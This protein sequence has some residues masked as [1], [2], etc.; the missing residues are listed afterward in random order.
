MNCRKNRTIF[1]IFLIFTIIKTP[2]LSFAANSVPSP[3]LSASDSVVR[4]VSEYKREY[5]TG[6]GFVISSDGGRVLIA[7]NYHVVEDNPISIAVYVDE[8]DTIT[9]HIICFSKQQ[10]LCIL[11]LDHFIKLQPIPLEK[12]NVSRGQEIYAIG[13]PASA[14]YLSD[15]FAQKSEEATITN[16]IISAIRELSIQNYG[17]PVSILQIN[18]D[19]NSGNS[20]GP[21]LNKTGNVVGINTYGVNDA[22]GINGAVNVSEL[23]NL[24]KD[25]NL[26]IHY[27]KN[28]GLSKAFIWLSLG[29][30]AVVLIIGVVL[31]LKKKEWIGKKKSKGLSLSAFLAQYPNGMMVRN[32]ISLLLPVAFQIQDYHNNGSLHLQVNPD[33]ILF[34][35][36]KAMLVTPSGSIQGRYSNGF[37]APEVF[38]GVPVNTSADVYSFASVLYYAITGIVP[39]N[40]NTRADNTL[41]FPINLFDETIKEILQTAMSLNPEERFSSMKDL[42][43]T[44]QPYSKENN[45]AQMIEKRKISSK[46]LF[47]TNK[48]NTIGIILG[49]ILG[50]FAIIYGITFGIAS[51]KASK[52]D[53]STAQ[54]FL[55]I[56]AVT[57]IH[58]S[59][60]EGYI[61]AGAA[62]EERHF[63]EAADKYLEL[64][65]YKDSK[66][67]YYESLTDYVMQLTNQNEYATAKSVCDQLD[68]EE[69]TN[70]RLLQLDV[71]FREGSY[72]L[73]EQKHFKRAETIFLDLEKEKY[74]KAHEMLNETYYLWAVD[75]TDKEDYIAAYK[76][77]QQCKGYE[78]TNELL[79]L[80]EELLYS[81]GIENYQSEKY[82][83][84]GKYFECIPGYER[85][86]D[87]TT[88]VQCHKKFYNTKEDI[89][90]LTKLIGFEDAGTLIFKDNNAFYYMEGGTF[91][92]TGFTMKFFER[93]D[94]WYAQWVFPSG[95]TSG[96]WE[97][98]DG[99]FYIKDT[100][101]MYLNAISKDSIEVYLINNGKYYTLTRQ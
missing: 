52:K 82:S 62:R 93:N 39:E 90:K 56:P 20:G 30:L 74:S 4:I 88:L 96:T 53:Y 92:T 49:C 42:I 44:I 38:K 101:I 58:S 71:M 89:S 41:V 29:I 60:L 63:K 3:V 35:N 2:I 40:A 45:S 70:A 87:Y 80:M 94:D 26:P 19:I 18:A 77:F 10:D 98:K 16:G 99:V 91:K 36:G 9:A 21:L 57:K 8:N 28:G 34:V 65:E 25:N 79:N 14:D 61:E 31:L 85:A 17:T 6:S 50:V 97:F 15:T 24:L 11:E 22:Q 59:R 86:N 37:T 27:A 13:F 23:I 46:R 47:S 64:G 78:D 100:A 54:K 72:E 76:K 5:A 68:N 32:A 48:K 67:L 95:N 84:A 43:D 51:I 55:I 83:D 81:I 33:N 73:Y 69:Y 7:T 66:Q 12:D 75:Y 1:I